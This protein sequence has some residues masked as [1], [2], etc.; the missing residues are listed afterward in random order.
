MLNNLKA[1]FSPEDDS[2]LRAICDANA[3]AVIAEIT[4]NAL[5]S[6][7]VTGT[8]ATG[9]PVTGTGTGNIS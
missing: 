3:A 2:L 6:T 8:S 9:G 1:S 5:V 7:T 4:Q